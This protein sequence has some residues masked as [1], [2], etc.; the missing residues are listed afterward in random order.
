MDSEAAKA[1]K[2]VEKQQ[3]F[4]VRFVNKHHPGFKKNTTELFWNDVEQIG[5][6]IIREQGER[7]GISK[8]T[9]ALQLDE[10]RLSPDEELLI[11]ALY[12]NFDSVAK[13]AGFQFGEKKVTEDALRKFS[14][15]AFLAK[16][17]FDHADNLTYWADDQGN[18]K[19]L[20]PDKSGSVNLPDL[21][22]ALQAKD[23]PAN[24][25]AMI[26][27]L[28]SIFNKIAKTGLVGKSEIDA[29][30]KQAKN[31]SDYKE[32]LSFY[33]DMDNIQATQENP[34]AHRLFGNE[35]N[36]IESITIDAVQQG[37]SG[38]CAVVASLASLTATRP[39]DVLQMLK[40]TPSGV[41]VKFPLFL[42]PILVKDPTSYELAFFLRARKN[43]Y[44]NW[45]LVIIKA[46]GDYIGSTGNAISKLQTEHLSRGEWAGINDSISKAIE[47]LTGHEASVEYL[48]HLSDKQ[49]KD[50]LLIACREKRIVVIGTG[51]GNKPT[52]DG[53]KSKHALSLL[54]VESSKAGDL[55]VTVRDPENFGKEH[56]HG[57]TK[58]TIEKLR[59]NFKVV[60]EETNFK[61]KAR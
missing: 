29:Y 55:T 21:D 5:S 47:I 60:C 56:P 25:R 41:H 12:E 40:E 1:V 33:R 50:L 58:I 51:F 43:E 32:M 53:Y 49:L 39:H 8:K 3:T 54:Q 45:P 22:R 14:K 48:D 35:K 16:S 30:W 15:R 42:R 17:N 24:D 26:V 52:A 20:S 19:K 23:L 38:D 2:P 6:K 46:F 28:K 27:D 34:V 7:N 4:E 11:G 31:T 61:L 36:P 10:R 57:T 37:R 13:D 9:L 18:L 59:R 44:G